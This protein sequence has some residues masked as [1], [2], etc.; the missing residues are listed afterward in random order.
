MS[1]YLD[2]CERDPSYRERKVKQAKSWLSANKPKRRLIED[3]YHKRDPLRYKAK[4][5]VAQKVYREQWPAAAELF[6]AICGSKAD[7]YH[8][9]FGYEQQHWYDVIPI[10][11]PCHK[12]VHS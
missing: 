12:K 2:R 8:H 7:H 10:C 1:Y 5:A 4:Q 6:C 9:H 3:R 11:V